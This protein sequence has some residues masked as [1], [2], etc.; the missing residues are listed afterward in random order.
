M[1]EQLVPAPT[2]TLFT[3]LQKHL[4]WSPGTTHHVSV[5]KNLS[6]P[7]MTVKHW[8]TSGAHL[9]QGLKFQGFL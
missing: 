2:T 7:Q 8:N 1:L 6:N 4:V 3:F 5:A 9:E